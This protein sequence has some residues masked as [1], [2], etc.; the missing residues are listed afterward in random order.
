MNRI[1]IELLKRACPMPALL[2]RIG[3]GDFAKKSCPSPFRPDKRPSWGIFPQ[4]GK[5]FFKDQATGDSGD[6]IALLARWKGLDPKRDFPQL[7][8]LY[9]EL[10]G[11]TPNRDE[12]QHSGV[13]PAAKE[14]DAFSWS[15]CVAAVTDAEAHRLSAWRGYSPEFCA[16]LRAENLIG[17]YKGNWTLPVHTEA[18][19]VAA[20]HYRVDR[21]SEQ[22]PDWFYH[23]KGIGV[24]PLIFGDLKRAAIAFVFE[25]PWDAFVVM[26]QLGWHKPKGIP[27]TS[28]VSTRGAGNGK[29]TAGLFDPLITAYA[30]K[31][32]DQAK[33]GKNPAD[34]WLADVCTHAGCKVYHVATPAQF[35]DVNDWVK[36][37][38][39]SADL[40][41]GIQDA[42]LVYSPPAFASAGAGAGAPGE[43][44]ENVECPP[45]EGEAHHTDSTLS[46]FSTPLQKLGAGIFPV[47]S[48]LDR[49]M[50]YARKREESADSFLLGSVIPVVAM[51]LARRVWL[52]WGDGKVFPNLFAMLAGPPGDRKSSAINMA[53][54]VAKVVIG[55]EHFLP[56]AMSA[57]AMFD[58]YDKEVGG[59]PDKILIADDANPFLG[60]VQ[61]TNYGERVGQTL[62]RL[63]DCKGLAE[64]FRRNK[65]DQGAL[66][67]YIPVT[68]TSVVLGATFNICQFQGHE[69]RSGLQRR[70]LYY[71]SDG[72]GRF[73]ALSAKS[74]QMEFLGLCERLAKLS[75]LD[76]VE[77]RLT[78]EAEERWIGFQ[79]E[80]RRRLASKG[81]GSSH[82]AYLA[83]LN[84]HPNHVQKVAMV[85]QAAIWAEAPDSPPGLIEWPTLQT[86]IDHTELCLTS[87]QALDSIANRAQ[88]Q[89]DA[90]VLLANITRDFWQKAVEG[91]VQLT[92]TDLT[93]TYA[94][95]SGRRGAL[96][97][98]D[99]YLRLIPNL[100]RRGKACEVPRPG[101]QPAF[102]FKMEE[103]P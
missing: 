93:S 17:L 5:W 97:P 95:H 3:L 64:T 55:N 63:Y 48:W 51:A 78:P 50:D 103:Q 77:F 82:D 1:D 8:K 2:V 29:L 75:N 61:K 49:Y 76:G 28:I 12:P 10:A 60:M 58:E 26:D 35:K 94:H 96:S 66:R 23:P 85:F 42:K 91:V 65:K 24:R 84:G 37:G 73:I 90:D 16:W 7:A 33:N 89:A 18:G 69:I 25:S 44:V 79:E 70:F 36:A 14:P 72:H 54:K 13:K 99:L 74:D 80:N 41:A 87:A 40:A 101:K 30:F 31:Q 59:S 62:L 46:T 43:D 47:G 39:G 52:P 27:R 32:N 98:D 9:A 88:I 6:E 34:D 22:K 68:S 67:R 15:A 81:F 20:C 21:G 11:I 92:K 4:E 71:L 19:A 38:A 100:V 53:E 45:G 86:A 83:R 56:D 102:D 57:E